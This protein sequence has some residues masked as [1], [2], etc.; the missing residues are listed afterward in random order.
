MRNQNQSSKM[1]PN[2]MADCVFPEEIMLCILTRLPVKSIL[3]FKSVCKPWLELF[4][5]P[6]FIKLHQGQFSSDSKN[7][8]FIAH[9]FNQS[10]NNTPNLSFFNIESNEKKP[11]FVGSP[12]GDVETDMVGCCNGLICI[13]ERL[14]CRREAICIWNPALNL[15]KTVSLP[16]IARRSGES[17]SLG[18][19]YD[20]ET[21]DYKVV[22][23]L[24]WESLKSEE[25]MI[26]GAEVYSVNAD[27]WTRIEPGFQFH[28][29]R[30][31]KN[32]I[33]L[34]TRNN[35]IVNGNPYWV[36]KVDDNG[37]AII[38]KRNHSNVLVYF[39]MKKMVFR[40]VPHS[41]LDLEDVADL[42]DWNGTLAAC[43][44]DK[45]V[46]SL[47]VWVFDEGEQ[48]WTKSCSFDPPS[49]PAYVLDVKRFVQFSRDGKVVYVCRRDDRIYLFDPENKRIREFAC[50]DR[51]YELIKIYGYAYTESLLCI[52]GME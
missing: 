9:K 24:S 28:V 23:I 47:D 22:R 48:I 20:A 25:N 46:G 21:D 2:A 41:R 10:G 14:R 8:F 13:I 1:P 49:C 5:T 11:T 30:T 7:K 44:C 4:S 34:G 52:K 51:P 15:S 17:V 39:D 31:F 33:V 3:R 35:T 19:G 16:S 12:F 50:G 43:V 29:T 36:A 38:V 42:V 27:S 6:E 18:F 37:S 26:N 45:M 40:T 32:D